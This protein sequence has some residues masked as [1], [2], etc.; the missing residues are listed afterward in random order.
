[1]S[2]SKIFNGQPIFNQLIKFIDKR[3][4]QKIAKQHGAGL[5]LICTYYKYVSVGD[6]HYYKFD[7]KIINEDGSPIQEIDGGRYI[8]I[9]Q[10][11]EDIYK[12][13]A[14]CYNY[15]V[16]PEKVWT[17]IYSLPESTVYNSYLNDNRPEILMDAFPNL[18][19]LK[20][21]VAYSLP[22]NIDTGKLHL[23]DNNGRAVNQF[24]ID[25]HSDLLLL[26]VSQSKRGVYH[27]FIEY[28]NRKTPLKK[29]V[30]N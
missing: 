2:K 4:I 23:F 5:A 28:G 1:M 14:Y 3:D 29:L 22:E 21:K 9:M 17:N 13:F 11:G 15:S 20:V 24:I 7:S 26:D 8:Y 10:T 12:L 30:I 16:F 19:T 27:Y 6:S 25:H 18:A